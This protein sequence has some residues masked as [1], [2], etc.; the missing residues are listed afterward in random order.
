M[1]SGFSFPSLGLASPGSMT[2]FWNIIYWLIAQAAPFLMILFAAIV[3][4][5]IARVIYTAIHPAQDPPFYDDE[6]E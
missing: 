1:S 4:G 5:M 2:L 6:E 3:M